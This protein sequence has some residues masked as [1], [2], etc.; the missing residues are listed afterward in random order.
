MLRANIKVSAQFNVRKFK[1]AA[2]FLKDD[3]RKYLDYVFDTYVHKNK[4]RL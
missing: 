4:S 2:V 1:S 3:V